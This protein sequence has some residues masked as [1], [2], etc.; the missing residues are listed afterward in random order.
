MLQKALKDVK[1]DLI[2]L[3]EL[4]LIQKSQTSMDLKDSDYR[5]YYGPR[6]TQDDYGTG[7]LVGP[8]LQPYV[9]KYEQILGT[10]RISRL[11]LKIG[12][13]RLAVYALYAPA[14]DAKL[15]KDEDEEQYE[16]YLDTVRVTIRTDR[17]GIRN[18][19][20]LGDLN[21]RV[22]RHELGEKSTGRFGIGTRNERGDALVLL[23]E[24]MK[25]NIQNTFTRCRAGRKYTWE[26]HN[27][28][29][30]NRTVAE[31]D[32]IITPRSMAKYCGPCWTLTR[33][34]KLFNS[35]HQLLRMPLTLITTRTRC[36]RRRT[37][38]RT[39]PK[40]NVEE[41]RRSLAARL[42]S[43]PTGP[44]AAAVYPVFIKTCLDSQ[45]AATTQEPLPPRFSTQTKDLL[46]KRLELKERARTSNPPT[47]DEYRRT[48]RAARLSMT[49]D[50]RRRRIELME[51]A[52]KR[53][54]TFKAARAVRELGRRRIL[55]LKTKTGTIVQGNKL[56]K[57]VKEYYEELYASQV[58]IPVPPPLDHSLLT[59]P[60]F[61]VEEVRA[62][63][64]RIAT[65]KAPGIDKLGAATLRAGG[66]GME[67][68]LVALFND[69]LDSGRLPVE[70]VTGRT[71]LMFKKGN[72][73]DLDNFRPITLLPVIY[74]LFT[75]IILKRLERTLEDSQDAE[76]TGFRPG[77]GTTDNIFCLSMLLERARDYPHKH[78]LYIAFVDYKK[79]FDTVEH[80]AVWR[81][82]IR[83]GAPQDLV[84]LLQAIYRTSEAKIDVNG[85]N[86]KINIGRGVRQGDP[87]SPRL[88]TAVLDD[89]L[90]EVDWKDGGVM[91]EGRRLHYLAYADDVVLLA[92][93]HIALE[94]MLKELNNAARRVGLEI[95]KKKT[96][97]MTTCHS[98][99]HNIQLDGTILERVE[100]FNLLGSTLAADGSTTEEVRRRSRL[101]W[102]AFLA[103]RELYVSR[104]V[105]M[106]LKK[107]LFDMKVIPTL[108]Y[109]LEARTL[110]KNEEKALEV[111]QR[112]MERRMTNLTLHHHVHNDELRKK[113]EVKDV[114][115]ERRKRMKRLF[116]K[117]VNEKRETWSR[118]MFEC[119]PDGKRRVG[120]PKKNWIASLSVISPPWHPPLYPHSLHHITHLARSSNLDSF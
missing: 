57:V 19:I 48:C 34:S 79:A 115:I 112:K 89:V 40:L 92:N 107:K 31:L 85:N 52:I 63:L 16:D 120:R 43:F 29:P 1:A 109:G 62:A 55:E 97:W 53:A 116:W 35:D 118:R 5:L 17:V 42:G 66:P 2:A 21:A 88:F 91:V 13:R 15:T 103:D 26:A 61:L 24:E 69:C 98:V 68:Y 95:S 81:A 10:P 4:A 3:T 70:L 27:S 50:L 108:L 105:P 71:T 58:S 36:T 104:M 54:T 117:M 67:Q 96:V 49:E 6:S 23:C 30:N 9:Q 37:R 59:C 64:Q 86:V 113:T 46:K 106:Q 94:D 33:I 45:R 60:P 25:M 56:E 7:F 78:K 47:Q 51:D 82:L 12:R 76:Q 84:H 99:H 65:N 75:M 93:S 100:T 20:L 18:V 80:S 83:R 39:T 90:A 44:M 102:A 38:P 110:K 111:V 41:L 119:Q 28:D 74:K 77:Y 73:L 72:T 101:G 14:S 114:T 8:A 32:Y 11:E 22:G 87:I